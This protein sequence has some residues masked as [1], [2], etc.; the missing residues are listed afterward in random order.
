MKIK[1]AETADEIDEV[2]RLFRDYEAHLGVDLC[3]QNFEQELAC[4]PGKYAAPSGALLIG[5][6]EGEVTGCVALRELDAGVCEMKRLFVRPE[7][8]RTGVGRQLAHEVIEVACEQGY[9]LM[10][11]DTL[12]RLKEAMRLYESLGFR[13]T[14]PFTRT[15]FQAWRIGR[16]T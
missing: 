12:D 13:K 9:S 5:L 16:W 11:L 4:L 3:F 7:S 2:R 6:T 1:R 14:E 15:R 8:R 10:R